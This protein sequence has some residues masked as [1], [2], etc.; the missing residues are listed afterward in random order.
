[1]VKT[2]T[3]NKNTILRLPNICF[4]SAVIVKR[5]VAAKKNPDKR[6][7]KPINI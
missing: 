3:K 4:I 6:R 7:K 5:F 2:G 1:M